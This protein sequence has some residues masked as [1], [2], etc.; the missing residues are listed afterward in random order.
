MSSGAIDYQTPSGELGRWLRRDLAAF[1]IRSSYLK[2]DPGRQAAI[3]KKYR[4]GNPAL[5]VGVSWSSINADIG[6][7]KSLS[8]MDLRF[9]AEIPGIRLVDLQYGDTADELRIFEEATGTAILHDD[10]IDQIADLDGFAAQVAAL[11]LVV[12]ISN[13]TAHLAGALGVDTFVMLNTVPLSC[14]LGEREDSPWYPSARLF[15]QGAP[16]D[17]SGVL[18]AVESQIRERV[19]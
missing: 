3:R 8:L 16:G 6:G 19:A 2:A 18:A 15:R 1:P 7:E 5:M 10:E 9:L 17:W 14:W 4:N 11:D 12:T 13:T